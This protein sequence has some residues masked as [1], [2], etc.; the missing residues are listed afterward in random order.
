[1]LLNIAD[2][3]KRLP[4]KTTGTHQGETGSCLLFQGYFKTTLDVS[5]ETDLDS[6]E[7]KMLIKE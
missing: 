3:E 5:V 2:G 4:W 7:I 1:M 6:T